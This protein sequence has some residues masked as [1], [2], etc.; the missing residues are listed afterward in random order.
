MHSWGAGKSQR[1]CGIGG[2]EA[3]ALNITAL[4][5]VR[6]EPTLHRITALQVRE[7]ERRVIVAIRSSSSGRL[8]L[9]DRYSSKLVTKFRYM[10]V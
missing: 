7:A 1:I 9:N 5:T 3:R 8:I 2:V 6:L 10:H 4:S